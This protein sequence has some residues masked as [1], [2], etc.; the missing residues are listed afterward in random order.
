L[1]VLLNISGDLVYFSREANDLMWPSPTIQCSYWDILKIPSEISDHDAPV[2][3]LRCTKSASLSFQGEFWL[4]DKLDKNKFIEK[5][6][7]ID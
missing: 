5:I 4:Y 6:E 3:C 1:S 2:I 7:Y